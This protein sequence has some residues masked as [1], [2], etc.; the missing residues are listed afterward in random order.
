SN[1]GWANSDEPDYHKIDDY[2]YEAS[3][4]KFQGIWDGYYLTIGAANNIIVNLAKTDLAS[5]DLIIAEAKALRAF[6]YF[7]L[8]TLFGEVPLRLINPLTAND[9]FSL[10]KSTKAQVYAQI[11]K[12]LND[13][14]A[15]LPE[16]GKTKYKFRISKEGAQ[17][18]L[19]KALLYQ[20][21][22]SAAHQTFEKIIQSGRLGLEENYEDVWSRKSEHGKESLLELSYVTTQKN[23]WG[24][25]KWGGRPE[26]NIHVQLMG[27]RNVDK[28][29]GF[30]NVESIGLVNGWGFNI[31]TAKIAEAFILEKDTIRKNASVISE[32]DALAKGVKLVGSLDDYEKYIR[33]KYVTRS[34]ETSN[35]GV[36]ALNY[37]I[38][39]RLI[40][41]ADVLLM[42][43]EA[44][45]KDGKDDKALVE[46]NKV[47]KR[48]KL[49]AVTATGTALFEAIVKER[50]LELAF[51]GQRF[52]DLVRWGK[53]ASTL[54]SKYSVANNTFP[55]P[56]SEMQLNP[57][58]K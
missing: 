27:P 28:S 51:E 58:I 9:D 32:A 31:P 37:G 48:V 10:P 24:N 53:A 22:W 16:K 15:I 14:I 29:P 46:L 47:R 5:K 38:N 55:I 34:S 25:F 30:Q 50:Q 39:W 45:H 43:A 20:E 7:E 17:A 41:Y 12:D 40:R 56:I 52:W 13:A 8:V 2:K 6:N 21:K 33:L 42:A 3:N 26:S 19:G 35:V 4:P 44:F 54:G 18:V 49:P 11:E 36:D 23:D 1:A 57:A